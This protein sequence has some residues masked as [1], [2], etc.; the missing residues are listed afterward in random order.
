KIDFYDPFDRLR[1]V[2]SEIESMKRESLK[3]E[4]RSVLGKKVK[5]LRRDGIIPG[6]VYGKD[7]NSQAVQVGKKEFDAV[8]KEAGETGLVDLKL[9]SQIIPV[10]IHNIA[11][12]YRNNVLHADFFKVNLKEK[13][14]TEVP[15]EFIGEPKAETDKTGLLMPI[16]SVIEIEA[17]PEELPESIQVNV[18]HLAQVDEQITVADL[19]APAGVTI[20]TDPGQV[21]VKVG[22]LISKEAQEQAAE[23]AAAAE[24]A[25]AETTEGAAPA[26]GEAPTEGAV[27]EGGPS[28]AKQE[29]L[30]ADKAEKP[31]K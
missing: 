3:V 7:I 26:E 10:L 20:I 12:D 27:T 5:K 25:A 13:I 15:I 22:E 8:F 2:V 31:A 29:D 14:K 19:K 9:D 17:L 18:E 24:A 1:I 11:T 6:N 4:K 28:E 30:P 21:V 23:E 16:M